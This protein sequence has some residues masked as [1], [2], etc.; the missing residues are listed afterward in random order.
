MKYTGWCKNDFNV[1]TYWLPVG[2]DFLLF[3]GT[4]GLIWTQRFRPCVT[5]FL[6][7][8]KPRAVQ[9]CSCRPPFTWTSLMKKNGMWEHDLAARGSTFQ[10]AVPTGSLSE[11]GVR[12]ARKVQVGPCIPVGMQL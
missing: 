6:A 7:T 10:V 4:A 5:T 3:V 8:A 9:S 1:Q 12:L 11:K 2:L